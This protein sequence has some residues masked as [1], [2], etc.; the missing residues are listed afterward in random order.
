MA[1][2]RRLSA[3]RMLVELIENGIEVEKQKQKEFCDL[4]D[5]FRSAADPEEVKR[6]GDPTFRSVR[7]LAEELQREGHPISYRLVAR[8]LVLEER[9]ELSRP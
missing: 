2:T 7:K 3:N 5:R 9:F 6:L 8:L 4:A 1:R